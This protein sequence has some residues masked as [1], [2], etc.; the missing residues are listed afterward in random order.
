MKYISLP[1]IFIEPFAK[2]INA[3]NSAMLCTADNH[4]VYDS[5][6]AAYI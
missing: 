2:P 4:M 1:P 5:S 3:S 6:N